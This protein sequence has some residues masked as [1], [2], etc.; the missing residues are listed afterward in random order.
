MLLGRWKGAQIPV[1]AESGILYLWYLFPM[2][3]LLLLTLQNPAPPTATAPGTS[4]QINACITAAIP[5]AVLS[6]ITCGG[7]LLV[8][9]P[10]LGA[11]HLVPMLIGNS[12]CTAGRWL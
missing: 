6:L 7:P 3:I 8:L 11:L 12:S 5:A 2:Y 10:V 1:S 4:S 9:P